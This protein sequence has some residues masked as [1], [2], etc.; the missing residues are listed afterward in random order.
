MNTVHFILKNLL[1]QRRRTNLGKRASGFTL[2]E[3]LVAVIMTFLI[4]APLLGIVTSLMNTDRQEQAKV[5]SQQEIQAAL[6]YIA[7]DLQQAV[8][9]YDATALNNTNSTTPTSGIKNQIPPNGGEVKGCTDTTECIPV[10]AFWKRKFL[11]R[12]DTVAGVKIGDIN[13]SSEGSDRFVYAL[14]VYYLIK[15]KE[16]QPTNTWSQVARIG[17]FEIRDGII[18]PAS[19]TP[20]YLLPP[21]PGFKQFAISTTSGNQLASLQQRMNT[22]TKSGNYNQTTQGVEILADYID[23]TTLS[24]FP[25]SVVSQVTPPTN[26]GTTA[27]GR[28]ASTGCE[29]RTGIGSS[30]VPPVDPLNAGSFYACVNPINDQGQ[31]VAQIYIRGNA[32]PRIS[33]NASAWQISEGNK[34]TQLANR[35]IASAL[36]SVRSLLSDTNTNP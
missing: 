7:Q 8:Y 33:K 9:I 28:L 24:A 19:V 31:S 3:L 5:S 23:D 2:I 4:I 15:D 35:P 11:D 12:D 36:V 16:Y 29:T 1:K 10:L 20:A 17:R 21:N 13:D 18:D 30:R 22:W 26:D 14:V 34:Q 25:A 27:S 6:D 32:L